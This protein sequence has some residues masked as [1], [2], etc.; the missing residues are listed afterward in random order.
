MSCS[1]IHSTGWDGLVILSTLTSRHWRTIVFTAQDLWCN[2]I[3]R[4]TESARHFSSLQTLL[5]FTHWVS[6]LLHTSTEAGTDPSSQAASDARDSVINLLIGCRYLPPGP[7]LPSYL[8]S[9]T[10]LWQVPDYTAWQL[11]V[12]N[13]P[14]VA[15]WQLNDKVISRLWFECS[16]HY[17]TKSCTLSTHYPTV[18]ANCSVTGV[19]FYAEIFTHDSRQ[20]SWLIWSYK[21]CLQVTL[22]PKH[23][24]KPYPRM[25]IIVI[26][27]RKEIK[28]HD[29]L[30]GTNSNTGKSTETQINHSR[31]IDKSFVKTRQ[32][33]QEP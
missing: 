1:S 18:G 29:Q 19:I 16:H 11:C 2:V 26:L 33:S 17:V 25:Q 15:I 20:G 7:Q 14:K 6:R 9:F 3:R 21:T 5:K 30:R 28:L 32:W 13:M 12:N 24:S 31:S 4:P 10:D 22:Q 23:P 27:R 8:Y